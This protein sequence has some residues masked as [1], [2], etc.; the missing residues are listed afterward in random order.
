M[1]MGMRG[2]FWRERRF[3][4]RLVGRMRQGMIK[5]VVPGILQL[6]LPVLAR[7]GLGND[8]L[9]GFFRGFRVSG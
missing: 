1:G 5:R 9:P 7:P 3:F 6:T 4:Q 8:A 2:V